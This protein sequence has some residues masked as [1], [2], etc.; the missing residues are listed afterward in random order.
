MIVFTN[1][2]GLLL[3][4]IPQILLGNTLFPACVRFLI[5]VLEK[6]TRWSEF[7]Y[8]LKNYKDLGFGHLLSGL[9][10]CLLVLTALCFT[11]VQVILFCVMEWKSEAMEGLNGYQKFVASV[12]QS[13]NSRH[14]GESIVD[15]SLL[16]PAILGLFVVMM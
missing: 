15:I 7:G 2:Y 5:R 14:A 3:V 10:S 9:D 6:N 8:M 1:N 4:L 12:F 13:V 16:T 11:A